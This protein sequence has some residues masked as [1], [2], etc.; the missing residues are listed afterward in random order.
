MTTDRMFRTR[1]NLQ[2]VVTQRNTSIELGIKLTVY[3]A[4]EQIRS[5]TSMDNIQKQSK[6]NQMLQYWKL[7]FLF[8]HTRHTVP[9]ADLDSTPRAQLPGFKLLSEPEAMWS[10]GQRR[11]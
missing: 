7:Y 1:T 11:V 3:F 2:F 10:V 4:S 6:A 9:N 8:P 5:C